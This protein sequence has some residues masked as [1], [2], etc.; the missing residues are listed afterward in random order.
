MLK[1]GHFARL[2]EIWVE[3]GVHF[4]APIASKTAAVPGDAPPLPPAEG[5]VTQV[6]APEVLQVCTATA[7]CRML[8]PAKPCQCK[9]HHAG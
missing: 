1:H 4:W 7:G 8:A 6:A 5:F 3:H 2:Q 9:A